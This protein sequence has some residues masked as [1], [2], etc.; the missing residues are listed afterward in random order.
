M[1]NSPRR[2]RSQRLSESLLRVAAPTFNSWHVAEPKLEFAHSGLCEDP[3]TG[4]T[5]FGPSALDGTPRTAIRVGVIGDGDSIQRLR[6]WIENARERVYAGLNSKGNPFDP[7]F[8][9]SFPGFSLDSPFQCDIELSENLT[10]VLTERDVAHVLS[11]NG[12]C[13]RVRTAIDIVS[14]KLCVLA[15]KEPSPDVVVVAVPKLIE[16]AIGPEARAGQTRPVPLTKLQKKERKRLAEDAKK[17]QRQLVFDE[18]EASLSDD[19]HRFRDF[20]NCLK[21]HAMKSQLATQLVWHSTLATSQ[22]KEDPATTAWNFFTA[23]YYKAGNVPWRLRFATQR[24][25]FVGI[26]FYKESP[27]P[28]APTRTCL[29]QAFSESGEGLVLRGER[30]TW[31]K[32]R[33]KKPH[34]SRND[35]AEILKRVLSLYE[36]HFNHR[37]NRVVLHKSSRYWPDE[38]DGFRSALGDIHAY[39]FL[40]LERRGIR[41]L[42]LGME[43]PVRGTVIQLGT[44]NYLI[45]TQ[46]Y[47]PFMRQYP[48]MRVPNPLEVV[49][50]FGDSAADRVCAEILALTKLNWNSCKFASSSPITISFSRQVAPI[51]KELPDGLDPATK[52]RFYM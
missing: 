49:E 34:L 17:G 8:A 1:T 37:P 22:G 21:A 30:V 29:A 33:D 44:K 25:C 23:L 2:T 7:F 31:D 19:T 20:H 38:L 16:L 6:N 32:E 10:V 14:S 24:T 3:K 27:D 42:R 48:G 26:T 40:A 45:Y 36:G 46:G 18:H 12:F 43:P 11:G 51:I 9:P 15:D 39:D 13:D 28:N 50:H 47:V 41:F 5:V 52:Y 4:L 35:A